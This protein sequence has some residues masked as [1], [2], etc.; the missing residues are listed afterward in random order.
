M[1]SMINTSLNKSN[2]LGITSLNSSLKKI[3][4]N[5]E[6]FRTQKTVSNQSLQFGERL[7]RKSVA[8]KEVKEKKSQN[9][10]MSQ[11]NEISRHCSFK[12]KLNDESCF[13]TMRRLYT[14]SSIKSGRDYGIGSLVSSPI[15]SVRTKNKK[16]VES[17]FKKKEEDDMSEVR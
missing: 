6:Q 2:I 16:V 13:L 10:K 11:E 1:K 15:N 14:S 3:T 8:L 12:P 4:S 7:Y 5:N 17:Y 9:L